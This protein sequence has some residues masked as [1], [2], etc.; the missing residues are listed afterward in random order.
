MATEMQNNMENSS[1]RVLAILE[2]KDE[3]RQELLDILVPLVN[4]AREEEGNIS[5][6]LYCSTENPNEFLFD[7]VWSNKETFNKHYESQ[8]S[9]KDRDMVSPLLAKPL[10]IKTYLEINKSKI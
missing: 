2:S 5:Y 9:Y 6:D 7:E 1:F 3:R 10:Q 8:K 4:P